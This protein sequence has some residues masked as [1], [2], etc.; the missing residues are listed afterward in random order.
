M[1]KTARIVI[2]LLVLLAVSISVG[3]GNKNSTI[4]SS[5]SLGF[6]SESSELTNSD[7]FGSESSKLTN[8]DKLASN[9]S[10]YTNSDK[11]A[12]ESSESTNS[13]KAVSQPIRPTTS[14][15]VADI[16]GIR[17]RVSEILETNI[18]LGGVK[19]TKYSAQSS[20]P[21]ASTDEYGEETIINEYCPQS[22]NVLTV[23]SS[24]EVKIVSWTYKSDASPDKWTK[25]TVTDLAKNYEQSNPGW[26][27]IAAVNGEFFDINANG[28]YGYLPY[29]TMGPIK[30]NG[31]TLKPYNMG[32]CVIGFKNDGSKNPVVYN[33]LYKYS[34][35]PYLTVYN[36]KNEVI[37]E[38]EIKHLNELPSKNEIAV[39]YNYA[40]ATNAFTQNKAPS[41]SY[42]SNLAS[43]MLGM[44][45]DSLYARG[46]IEFTE[47]EKDLENS[48][49]ALYT[50]NQEVKSLLDTA[51]EVKIEYKVVG[52]YEACDNIAA[53]NRHLISGGEP[54]ISLSD[55]RHPRTMIGYRKD[56]TVVIVTV[57]GRQQSKGMYG[58]TLT[59]MSAT[60]QYYDCFEATNMDGGGSTTMIIKENGQFRVLN[61]PSDGIERKVTNAVL[62]VCKK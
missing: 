36:K 24:K 26:S 29:Q 49:F 6:M 54:V 52:D 61:S 41:N 27:V 62:V 31:E 11:P 35:F 10:K 15:N 3:C 1:N 18:L 47:D 16:Y 60:M 42:F 39:Y 12:P 46:S 28:S 43:R 45:A 48:Q 8:S 4:N 13:D 2:S 14:E 59:E 32:G 30:S 58:M 19:H 7:E 34:K 9:S 17:Y 55:T 57:D 25:K 51:Y 20:F 53:G 33:R 22:V 5:G 56:G 21:K 23:P 38:F 50:Q 44:G 37:G 40:H